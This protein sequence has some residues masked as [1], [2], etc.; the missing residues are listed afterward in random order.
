MGEVLSL[1]FMVLFGL[2][3]GLIGAQLGWWVSIYGFQLSVAL[4]VL[5]SY[6]GM[7]VSG[8]SFG[9]VFCCDE[10]SFG[11]VWLS[12]FIASL[13]L[14]GSGDVLNLGD[15]YWVFLVSVVSLTIILCFCFAVDS[16]FMFYVFFEFSLIPT[17][18]IICGWGYQPERLRAGKYMMLYTVGASLPLLV[19]ILFLFYGEGSSSFMLIYMVSKALPCS[20]IMFMAMIMAFL[21]KSPMYGVHGWLPKAHV[22]APVAGSMFLAGVLLKLGGY[23]LVRF[24]SLLSLSGSV[25]FS[26]VICLC[27]FGGVVASVVCCV[28]TDAK[29]LVAYSSVGHMSLV[30]GGLMSGSFWGLGGSCLLMVAHG[31][32][33]SGMF[34]LVGEFYKLYNSRML[35]V[36]RGGI[37]N[38]LGLNLWLAYM[39]GFNAS[40]PPSL[41]LC[42]EVILCIS[43]VSYS[44]WFSGLVGVLGFLSCLYSWSLY[45]NTQTG[46]YPVWVRPCDSVSYFH[47]QSMV[48]SSIVFPLVGLSFYCS[49]GKFF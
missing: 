3:V 38:L 44:L 35:F 43:I 29:S 33:S 24:I 19:F 5:L 1:V 26:C 37:G 9:G 15:K 10:V 46:N 36:I 41:S 32:S 48:C 42:G 34:F 11:F 45:C 20:S 40:A 30:L 14:L 2:L 39:C 16:L 23:G 49:L 22:E 8:C 28:Q 21:V 25:V 7:G 18:M 4:V 31:L 17:L 27:I 47:V 13:S 6:S 12:I